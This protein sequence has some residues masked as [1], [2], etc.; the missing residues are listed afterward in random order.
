M[1]QEKFF[2]RLRRLFGLN[3]EI[4]FL[5]Y[6]VGEVAPVVFSAES[7]AMFSHKPILGEKFKI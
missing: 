4:A 5:I 7:L 1:R 2:R 6:A 3:F